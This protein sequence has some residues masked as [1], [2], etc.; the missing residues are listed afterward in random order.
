MVDLM[1]GRRSIREGFSDQPVP[2]DAIDR[3]L[4]CGLAAP[5]SKNAQPWRI[6][7]VTDRTTM[8]DLADA[9]QH[10][11]SADVYV[12]VDPSTGKARTDWESTVAASAEVLRQVPLGLFI[13]NRGK[14]SDGR[15]TVAHAHADVRED[16][17]VGYSFEVIGL[18]AS[19]FSMWMA[20]RELGLEG[21]FMGDI[22]VAEEAIRARLAMNGDLVGVLALGY[23]TGEAPPKELAPDRVVRHT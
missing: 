11:K 21:V 23:S 8:V 5:S 13:E 12:P 9:V 19:I 3:I 14:F 6:H 22:L 7:V 18:G 20:G 4:G 2:D 17:L 1:L 16:A 10:A 15:A